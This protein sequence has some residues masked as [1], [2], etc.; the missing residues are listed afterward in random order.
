MVFSWVCLTL[1]QVRLGYGMCQTDPCVSGVP[2]SGGSHCHKQDGR[3]LTVN[4]FLRDIPVKK[5][6][7]YYVTDVLS[8]GR[9]MTGV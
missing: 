7:V 9:N 5:F 8:H 3:I 2:L 1:S 6:G 4:R